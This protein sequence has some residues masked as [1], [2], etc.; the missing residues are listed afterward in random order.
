MRGQKIMSIV[1][2]LE[3]NINLS[4]LTTIEQNNIKIHHRK[5]FKVIPLHSIVIDEEQAEE[6][7][8][9]L[10]GA[11]MSQNNEQIYKANQ[12]FDALMGTTKIT[13]GLN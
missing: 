12:Y 9:I 7:Y 1:E 13:V 6:A 10:V 2:V 3:D 8:Q 4:H 5:S 11:E